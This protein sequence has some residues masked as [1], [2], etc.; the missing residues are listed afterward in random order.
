[1]TGQRLKC[2][3]PKCTFDPKSPDSN[4]ISF[5]RFPKKDND[6][7]N[8]W[9]I[10]CDMQI[11]NIFPTTA[12]CSWHF[13]FSD[14]KLSK[15][16]KRILNKSVWP[17]KNLN[18]QKCFELSNVETTAN[19]TEISNLVDSSVLDDHLFEFKE[20][21][22][23][24]IDTNLPVESD[25]PENGMNEEGASCKAP[26]TKPKTHPISKKVTYQEIV[27]K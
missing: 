9:L 17:T 12:V 20:K 16:G 13:E 1:M 22:I 8:K 23:S 7:L 21:S 10:A 27:S 26:S 19:S 3:V 18:G 4:D 2:E 11:E 24:F 6:R 5:H 25:L 15:N 14:Y